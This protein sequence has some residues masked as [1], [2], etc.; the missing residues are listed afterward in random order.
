MAAAKQLTVYQVLASPCLKEA[1]KW[2]C[3]SVFAFE[4]VFFVDKVGAL[5]ASL[6]FEP[7]RLPG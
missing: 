3:V 4:N 1:L 7:H 2:H 6:W 5:L